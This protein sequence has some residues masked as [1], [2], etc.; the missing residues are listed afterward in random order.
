LSKLY[1]ANKN[2]N[3]FADSF[4]PYGAF[5]K[6]SSRALGSKF[7]R[8]RS[9]LLGFLIFMAAGCAHE[10]KRDVASERVEGRDCRTPLGILA[11]GASTSGFASPVVSGGA[12]CQSG[13]ISCHDGIWTGSYIY[14]ACTIMDAVP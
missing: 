14:P 8:M 6:Y 2:L 10:S 3:E 5:S 7:L 9:A 4:R 13:T 12:R 11:D 1:R